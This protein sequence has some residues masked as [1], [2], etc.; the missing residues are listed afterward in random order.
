MLLYNL[1]GGGAPAP[2]YTTN[3]QFEANEWLADAGA[4]VGYTFLAG[5]APNIVTL[6]NPGL[7]VSAN[8][9]FAVEDADLTRRQP[10]HF[11]ADPVELAKWNKILARQG[12]AFQFFLDPPGTVTFTLP[13][14]PAATTL[15]RVRAANL[16]TTVR[17]AGNDMTTTENCDQTVGEVIG[18][19]LSPKPKLGSKVFIG[20]TTIQQ[21]FFDYHIA[22]HLVHGLPLGDLPAA[23]AALTAAQDVIAQR[24]GEDTRAVALALP[25]PHTPTIAA[26]MQTVR[27]NEFARPSKVG[28]GLYSGSLGTVHPLLPAGVQVHDYRNNVPVTHPVNINQVLWG[29]HWGGIIAMDGTDYLTLENYARNAEN[30]GGN[31]GGLFY[32]QMYGAAAGETWHEQWTPPHI[33]G[34]AFANPL[35]VL[36]EPDGL[37]GLRYFT[38]GSKANHLAVGAAT[39][40]ASLQVALLDGLNYAT[41]HLY[42]EKLADEYADKTR[43]NNWRAEVAAVLAA[44]P[45][46]IDAVTTSLAQHVNTALLAVK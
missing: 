38:P 27:V 12:S 21:L 30:A 15:T 17:A 46:W 29:F 8:G 33:H 18:S 6:A 9:L 37:A 23:P 28:Q 5:G 41:M 16:R 34:K 24:F 19:V 43:R 32:F 25:P 45:L 42:A 14:A 3:Q 26:D 40:N 20:S 7:R 13:G 10:K 1:A 4:G 35:T 2:T 31:G 39:D 22:N 36:V 44:P 11:F